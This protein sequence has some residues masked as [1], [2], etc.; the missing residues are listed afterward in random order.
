MEDAAMTTPTE[1]DHSFSYGVM[2]A[3]L[4]SGPGSQGW[5]KEYYPGW[6]F[7][8]QRRL[9]QPNSLPALLW[10]KLAEE[11]WKMVGTNYGT[12]A[13]LVALALA[14]LADQQVVGEASPELF[15]NAVDQLGKIGR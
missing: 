10:A 13:G 7:W 1:D 11:A 15:R 8:R 9:P 14:R 2:L 4:G 6:E 12:Q 5:R 3:Q